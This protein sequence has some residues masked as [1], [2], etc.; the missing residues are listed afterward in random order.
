MFKR[1]GIALAV[2]ATL[3]GIILFVDW[4]TSKG[5]VVTK[6]RVTLID[7]NRIRL[8]QSESIA[9]VGINGT[10]KLLPSGC[11]GLSVS[12]PDGEVGVQVVWQHGSR[13]LSVKPLRI[14]FGKRTY[15]AGD[16]ISGGGYYGSAKTETYYG[17][18]P[19]ACKSNKFAFLRNN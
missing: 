11:V 17:K 13:L 19:T 1:T 7:D 15:G 2:L 18:I 6:D 10:L 14:K 8:F 9:G 4:Q 5:S 3:V 16:E 12:R